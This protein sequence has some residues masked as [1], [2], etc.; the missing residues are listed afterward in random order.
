MK[1]ATRNT[2][3]APGLLSSRLRRPSTRVAI[4]VGL[5]ILSL[6]VLLV[7]VL[8]ATARF[9]AQSDGVRVGGRVNGYDSGTRTGRGGTYTFYLLKFTYQVEGRSYN[10]NWE[11][12]DQSWT[13]TIPTGTQIT[14]SYLPG[15]PDLG[16]PVGEPFDSAV[17]GQIIPFILVGALTFLVLIV[18]AIALLRGVWRGKIA[19]ALNQTQDM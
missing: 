5:L 11:V 18:I 16:H 2:A 8:D 7:V 1:K 15:S 19:R 4:A 6:I 12:P 17:T 10:G 3:S 14:I 9:N 13:E